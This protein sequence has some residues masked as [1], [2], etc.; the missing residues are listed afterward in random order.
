[1]NEKIKYTIFKTRWG[2][3]GF[4]ANGKALLRTVLPC[5]NRQT[6][7]R[8]LL[9][10]LENPEFDGNLLK[11]LKGRIIA[12]FNG[13]SLRNSFGISRTKSR[14]SSG[15][16]KSVKFDLPCLENLPAFTRKVL[17][18]C[19]EIPSG[20]TVSYSQ[21]A[22]MIGKPRAGRAVG[23]ALAR[24]PIP[25]IIPCHRIIRTNGSI[26]NFSAPGGSDTKRKLLALENRRSLVR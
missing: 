16:G 26:G 19:G 8:Y 24:N 20:K 3:F 15:F 7:R 13:K 4:A 11:S 12:Y 2:Y 5:P 10:G 9:D 18:A 6:T 14:K 17:V 23:N 21:L 25:L 1:M 22:R